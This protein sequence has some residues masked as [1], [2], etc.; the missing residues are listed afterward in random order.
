M[1]I[2]TQ[3]IAEKFL[4]RYI[5]D[6]TRDDPTSIFDLFPGSENLAFTPSP[7]E[8]I[9]TMRQGVTALWSPTG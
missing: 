6:L 7:R 2:S 9:E 1:A 3:Q 4:V 5:K 8:A